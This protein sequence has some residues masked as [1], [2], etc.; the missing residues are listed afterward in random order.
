MRV[1]GYVSLTFKVHKEN[2]NW[3]ADCVELGTSAFGDTVEKAIDALQELTELHLNE[4]EAVGERA[5][6]FREHGI[7]THKRKPAPRRARLDIP[8]LP[9]ELAERRLVPIC[10]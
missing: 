4:L 5:H 1:T 2:E 10:G 3:V 8:L 9:E 7:R 6:F